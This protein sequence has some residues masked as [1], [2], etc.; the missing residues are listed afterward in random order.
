MWA[1]TRADSGRERATGSRPHGCLNH[2][3]GVFLLGFLW[4]IT[5][6]CLVHSPQ[7]VDLKILLCE[8]MHLLAKMDFTEKASG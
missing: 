7:L 4:P 3:Y 8:C 6:I 5:V 2:F 1:D